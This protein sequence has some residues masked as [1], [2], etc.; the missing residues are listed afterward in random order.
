MLRV[1]APNFVVRAQ[2]PI[3]LVRSRPVMIAE[4]MTALLQEQRT[5]VPRR[6]S[7][8]LRAEP[9]TTSV[10]ISVSQRTAGC[11]MPGDAT[12]C[13]LRWILRGC[14]GADPCCVALGKKEEET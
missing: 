4:M 7:A 10:R 8:Y 2:F 13:S 3:P 14:D 11:V 12:C 5:C 6:S 9:R 1:T